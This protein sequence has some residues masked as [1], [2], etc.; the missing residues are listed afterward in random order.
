MVKKTLKISF[1][2]LLGSFL[3]FL[4]QMLIA[5]Y[6]GAT[7]EFDS[8]IVATTYP[9]FLNGIITISLNYYLIPEISKRNNN[10][11][12]EKFCSLIFL[13]FIVLGIFISLFG[14]L[15]SPLQLSY[16][17][18]SKSDE[19]IYIA[20]LYWIASALMPI[21]GLY[22][23]IQITENKVINVAKA[24]LIPV[25]TTLVLFLV[26]KNTLGFRVLAYGLLIGNIININYLKPIN[27][28]ILKLV[29]PKE[30]DYLVLKS[31]YKKTPLI[32]LSILCF[33]V[34]QS[35]DVF[36]CKFLANNSLSYVSYMQR[37][38]VAFTA[39]N[40][41]TPI[42]LFLPH[43]S[44]NLNSGK[45]DEA[46]RDI[47]KIFRVAILI[48]MFQVIFFCMY[49]ESLVSILFQR[50]LFDSIATKNVS[51]LIEISIFSTV[52]YVGA[53]LLIRFLFAQYN[54]KKTAILSLFITVTYFILSGIFTNYFGIIGIPIAYLISW[55]FFFGTIFFC[56]YKN[57]WYIVFNLEN[58]IFVKNFMLSV[59]IFVLLSFLLKETFIFFF[60]TTLLTL[61]L[62]FIAMIFIYFILIVKLFPIKDLVFLYSKIA[63]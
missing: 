4:T 59:A 50:G 6:F 35:I 14:Y 2:S 28:N 30:K 56:S 55:G 25:F 12:R 53:I 1:L 51:R 19:F 29:K 57:Y 24:H 40:I 34:F 9:L 8:F 27:F 39:L 15:I 7:S 5:K 58:Y 13:S 31:F 41:S 32:V 18:P 48:I 22:Q 17:A 63:K 16:F 23:S 46:L 45:K 11:Q 60:E 62:N 54:Y 44:A 21:L 20:R 38:L 52:F 42:Q 36:W 43:L 37:F 33:T 49:S 10:L 61:M 26:F 3:G 47:V